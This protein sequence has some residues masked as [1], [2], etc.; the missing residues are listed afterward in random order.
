MPITKKKFKSLFGNLDYSKGAKV[1]AERAQALQDLADEEALK[2]QKEDEKFTWKDV[3]DFGKTVVSGLQQ[4]AGAVADAGIQASTV[5]NDVKRNF[6]FGKSKDQKDV[7]RLIEVQNADTMRKGLHGLTDL[8]NNK[9]TGTSGADESANKIRT[10]KADLNDVAKV[11]V[12]GL[13]VGAN[14]MMFADP[15]ASFGKGVAGTAG[16][17]VVK[18]VVNNAIVGAVGGGAE[19]GANDRDV[20]SGTLMGAAGGGAMSLGGQIL[21]KVAG[22]VASK[23]KGKGAKA[24]AIVTDAADNTPTGTGSAAAKEALS[25]VEKQLDDVYAGNL[26][27]SAYDIVDTKG[28]VVSPEDIARATQKQIQTLETQKAQLVKQAET[29]TDVGHEAAIKA[30]NEIDDK[31]NAIKNGDSTEVMDMI[32]EGT[33]RTPN[34]ERTRAIIQDLTQKRDALA[35][36]AATNS[37]LGGT[38]ARTLDEVDTEISTLA[39]GGKTADV[40]VPHAPVTNVAE[41]AFDDSMPIDIRGASKQVMDNMQEVEGQLRLLMDKPTY[42]S[43]HKQMDDAYNA[44]LED[45]KAMPEPRQEIEIEK[46][47]DQYMKDLDELETKFTDDGPQVQELE[48]RKQHLAA[49]EQEIIRDAQ[50]E[51]DNNP[52]I[53]AVRDEKL[54]AD[55]LAA[56]EKERQT[57]RFTENQSPQNGQL[58]ASVE[59]GVLPSKSNNPVTQKAVENV[60]VSADNML[61]TG[62]NPGIIGMFAGM[63]RRVL[64]SFGEAGQKI[65]KVLDEAI[66]K[67]ATNDH[68]VTQQ[69]WKWAEEVGGLKK[70]NQI[71]KALDGDTAAFSALDGTQQKVFNQV[72]DMFNNYA[73]RLGI[74]KDG[75]IKDYLPHLFKDVKIDDVDAAV[76]QLTLG[77]S[78]GGQTLSAAETKALNKVLKGIDYEA[79][80]MVQKNSMYSVKNGFLEKRTGAEG[81]SFNLADVILTYTHSAHN[82]EFLK[83]AYAVTKEMSTN[84]NASQ[85]QYLAKVIHSVGGRPTDELGDMLNASLEAIWAGENKLYTNVSTQARKWIYDAT[86]GLNV[87]ASVKNLSQ[88][89]NTYAKLGNQYYATGLKEAVQ[90]WGKSSAGYSELLEEGVLHNKYSDLLRNGDN[91]SLVAHKA[92]EGLWSMFTKVEQINR[93]TAYFG[94]KNRYLDKYVAKTGTALADISDDVMKQAKKA[95]REMSRQTQFE[96]SAMDNPIGL[97]SNTAK[98]LTQFQSYNMSQVRFI[99]D[100]IVGMDDSLLVK[101]ASGKGYH[102]TKEGSMQIARLVGANLLFISTLGAA[103]GMKPTDMIPYYSN[104]KD[105]EV[106]ESPIVQ[107]LIGNKT[108]PGLTTLAGNIKDGDMEALADNSLEYGKNAAAMLIPGGSQA[109]KT[110]EGISA[111]NTGYST[112]ASDK[113]QFAVDNDPVSQTQNAIFGKYASESGQDWIS[114]GF[115]TLTDTQSDQ[116]RLQKSQEA[117]KQYITFYQSL[118]GVTGRQD[119]YDKAVEKARNGNVNGAKTIIADYNK[120]VTNSLGDYFKE[121]D[122]IPSELRDYMDSKVK[123]KIENIVD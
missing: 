72:R 51:I 59:E 35:K 99:K 83:P 56:L 73:D 102:M 42:D 25:V 116:V 49:K 68:Q 96:F 21:G 109:K 78:L 57:V 60:T 50:L 30:V 107:L 33:Q 69:V 40:M 123:I 54:V 38:A 26:P 119:V 87:G 14:A 27:D 105:G 88:G 20:L 94:A 97:Q 48:T 64:N 12:T 8:D 1:E 100:M 44:R 34:A 46:L 75:R 52:D 31:I 18:N 58:V 76:A 29:A 5:I 67:I 95:G 71:S 10:G 84:L 80:A 111:G 85:N 62:K 101:N 118:K 23:I 122:T 74:P 15:V 37:E 22:K 53:Y 39:N 7:E 90:S 106:P 82:T 28:S 45:I 16:K 121:Y 115:P 92:E 32:G 3:G 17:T 6:E 86:M 43:A 91:K 41:V 66:D 13:N 114:K 63:P 9:I 70:F 103:M 93:A 98:N 112:N 55:K 65:S 89:A 47:V 117:K 110:I 113:I 79:L 108:K 2:K 120:S 4:G 36:E 61:N 104:I 11:G 24:A 19:A 77:K 81:Y